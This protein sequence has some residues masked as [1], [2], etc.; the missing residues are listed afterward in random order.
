MKEWTIP[1]NWE[2]S[3]LVKVKAKTLAEAIE[4]AKK[5]GND[6]PLPQDGVYVDGSWRVLDAEEDIANLYN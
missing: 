6:I 5:E 2:M 4:Y 3:A 1:V